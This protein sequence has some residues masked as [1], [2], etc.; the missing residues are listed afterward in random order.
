[1]LHTFVGSDLEFVRETVRRPFCDYLRSSLDL[2]GNLARSWGRD[3]AAADFTEEDMEALLAH[4]FDRY[5]ETS[6]LMGTPETCLQMIA[7]LQEIGVD[8]VACLIDFGVAP[9]LVLASLE[10]LD[11]VRRRSQQLGVSAR[12]PVSL[13][14]ELMRRQVSHLQCTPSL[15]RMLAEDSQARAAMRSLRMLL[16]GG[17]ALPPDLAAQLAAELPA[18]IVNMYGP[19][20][21]TIWSTTHVLGNLAGPVPIGRPI[22][23]TQVYLLDRHL[24]PVPLGVPGELYI[25]GAGVA[26]GYL[27]RPDLTAAAFIPNPFAG[28]K[29]TRRPPTGAWQG[30]KETADDEVSTQNLKL[31]TQNLRLYRTGDL[32]RYLPDGTIMFLGRADQQVKLRGFRIELGE[33]EAVLRQHPGVREAVVVMREEPPDRKQLVAYIVQGSGVRGPPPCLPPPAGGPRG[34]RRQGDK[35]TGR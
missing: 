13:P 11:G 28:D 24:N 15:A 25:G 10:L 3:I 27:G 1:M 4:A 17:E 12:V 31:K 18:T 33:I 29:E 26:R 30:D 16:L 34:A 9:D 2:I 5:F 32:A 8:E 23:N 19:T 6:G 35:E 7:Q 14:D 21:T 22:A 20:E